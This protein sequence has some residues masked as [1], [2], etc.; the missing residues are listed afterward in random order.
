MGWLA[1]P[2]VRVIWLA[3]STVLASTASPNVRT[4]A[5]GQPRLSHGASGWPSAAHPL[6]LLAAQPQPREP[7][8][9]AARLKGRGLAIAS[10]EIP[11]LATPPGML[12]MA[13]AAPPT[14]AVRPATGLSCGWS[15]QRQLAAPPPAAAPVQTERSTG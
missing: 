14:P 12:P 3:I 5:A 2:S 7:G 9:L 11:Q 15:T 6:P 4:P 8:W 1:N 13:S 10:A